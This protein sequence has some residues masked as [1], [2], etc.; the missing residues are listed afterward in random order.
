MLFEVPPIALLERR[1]SDTRPQQETHTHKGVPLSRLGDKTSVRPNTKKKN[2]IYGR[3]WKFWSNIFE[4][5]FTIYKNFDFSN[6]QIDGS[7]FL[8]DTDVF[9]LYSVICMARTACLNIKNVSPARKR[10]PKLC[11]VWRF[12][13]KQSAP[14][15][16]CWDSLKQWS[17]TLHCHG[18][19]REFPRIILINR[20]YIPMYT[21][22]GR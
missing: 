9:G 17:W 3:W 8:S 11:T 20:L 18:L 19:E 1:S 4:I 7:R 6:H 22:G 15:P 21:R 12:S 13:R 10:L 16:S 14:A 5:F 2:L